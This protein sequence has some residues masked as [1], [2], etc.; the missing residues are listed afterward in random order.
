MDSVAH[1]GQMHQ[2]DTCMI[3][4]ARQLAYYM[5]HSGEGIKYTHLMLLCVHF[6]TKLQPVNI[7][8]FGRQAGRYGDGTVLR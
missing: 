5:A 2:L 6:C 4:A 1:L 8:Y 3:A 7:S